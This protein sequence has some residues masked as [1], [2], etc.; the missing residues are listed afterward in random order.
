VGLARAF[1]VLGF[2]LCS[3]SMAQTPEER[4]VKKRAWYAAN[5]E[6]LQAK[7]RARY[8]DEAERRCAQGKAYRAA[9]SEKIRESKR[10][11]A[12]AHPEQEAE[13]KRAWQQANLVLT[14]QRARDW[15]AAHPEQAKATQ[16]AWYEA[17]R[18]ERMADIREWQAANPERVRANVRRANHRRR[19]RL[20]GSNSPGVTREEW[21]AVVEFFDGCCAY[22]GKPA[23]ELDH[24]VPISRGGRDALDNV[25]PA[26]RKC[27][28]SKNSKL[29]GEWLATSPYARRVVWRSPND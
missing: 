26:C 28:A 11:Y 7:D 5:R 1:F 13:R 2:V 9:N 24:I 18:D 12:Q 19:A 20:A 22:C 17:H 23:T 8:A 29:L 16:R 14:Q 4:K 6:Q 21:A 3:E 27:N 15:A 10:Q 25:Q